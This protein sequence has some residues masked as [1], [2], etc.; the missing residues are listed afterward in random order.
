M[1]NAG[2]FPVSAGNSTASTLMWTQHGR[3]RGMIRGIRPPPT[4]AK[5]LQIWRRNPMAW[6][7]R[8]LLRLFKKI[9]TISLRPRRKLKQWRL[10]WASHKKASSFYVFTIIWLSSGFVCMT[11]FEFSP[12]NT[13][14]KFLVSCRFQRFISF[15][16]SLP[17]ILVTLRPCTEWLRPPSIEILVK[18]RF[19]TANLT[20]ILDHIKIDMVGLR[21]FA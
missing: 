6:S 4:A 2:F 8:V 7:L 20:Q 5:G 9:A 18:H 12:L 11:I 14:S 19:H 16:S 17:Q 10:V 13:G 1:F 3:R 21:K 15:I